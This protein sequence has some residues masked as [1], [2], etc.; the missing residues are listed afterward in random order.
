ME[1][2]GA[3]GWVASGEWQDEVPNTCQGQTPPCPPNLTSNAFSLHTCGSGCTQT[4]RGGGAEPADVPARMTLKM[5]RICLCNG[6]GG[7]RVIRPRIV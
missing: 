2:W 4:G 1:A 7:R 3:G 6:A 5:T